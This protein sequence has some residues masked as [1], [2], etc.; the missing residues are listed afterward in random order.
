VTLEF[1]PRSDADRAAVA[2]LYRDARVV[3][4]LETEDR[5]AIEADVPR[6]LLERLG[7]TRR[8]GASA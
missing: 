1:D 4:H 3:Q 8:I 6:R 5:L 7:R 2:R